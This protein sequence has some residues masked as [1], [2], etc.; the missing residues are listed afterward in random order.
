MNDEDMRLLN[1]NIPDADDYEVCDGSPL[2]R[3]TDG[4]NNSFL[5]MKSRQSS[6]NFDKLKNLDT[7][8]SPLVSPSMCYGG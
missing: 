2:I 7:T 3:I 1:L 6:A 5:L 8:N 4:S